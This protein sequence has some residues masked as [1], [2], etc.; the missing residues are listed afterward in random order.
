MRFHQDFDVRHA[1]AG[2]AFAFADAS[3]SPDERREVAAM[4]DKALATMTPSEL[5]GVWRH[6][7]SEIDIRVHDLPAFLASGRDAMAGAATTASR[8][9]VVRHSSGDAR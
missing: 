5:V 6:A 4:L 3:L 1:D 9:T 7:C 8:Q 2:E